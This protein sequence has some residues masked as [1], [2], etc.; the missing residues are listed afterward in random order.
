MY[1]RY[2]SMEFDNNIAIEEVVTEEVVTNHHEVA[3]EEEVESVPSYDDN[4]MIKVYNCLAPL[5]QNMNFCCDLLTSTLDNSDFLKIY[6]PQSDKFYKYFPALHMIVFTVEG[7]LFLRIYRDHKQIF[8]EKTIKNIQQILDIL[9]SEAYIDCVNQVSIFLTEL[10]SRYFFCKGAFEESNFEGDLSL[11]D[12][13]KVFVESQD[14]EIIYRSRQCKFLVQNFRRCPACL[15]LF[16]SI[17]GF[18]IFEPECSGE[19]DS[20]DVPDDAIEEKYEPFSSSFEDSKDF[21]VGDLEPSENSFKNTGI[22]TTGKPK[23]SYKRMII[24]AIRCSP[25][26]RL[27]LTEIYDEI[28]ARFPYYNKNKSGFQNSIRHNLSLSKIF[29]KIETNKIGKGSYWTLDPSLANEDAKEQKEKSQGL[30]RKMV[31]IVD[32]E[33]VGDNNF[34]P[35]IKYPDP[36]QH[37]YKDLKTAQTKLRMRSSSVTDDT[38]AQI[39]ARVLEKIKAEADANAVNNIP[40]TPISVA[41]VPMYTGS[42]NAANVTIY[43]GHDQVP[44]VTMSTARCQVSGVTRTSGDQ[45]A[46]VSTTFVDTNTDQENIQQSPILAP[47]QPRQSYAKNPNPS[48]YPRYIVVKRRAES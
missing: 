6:N 21:T 13:K 23:M 12:I 37:K 47:K 33:E 16:K 34:R 11:V 39:N 17:C 38:V 35:V 48:S 27:K 43:T 30:V 20:M 19:N 18:E 25:T 1:F 3:A 9:D 32:Y 10:S 28:L 42:D 46:T 31:K 40:L 7:N 22:I 45:V 2:L 15:E 29:V 8:K 24:N 26:G 14:A 36:Q 44:G 41:S 4:I 5:C